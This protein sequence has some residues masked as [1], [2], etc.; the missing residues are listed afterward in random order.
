MKIVRARHHWNYSTTR[1]VLG[2]AKPTITHEGDNITLQ[3]QTAR[4]EYTSVVLNRDELDQALAAVH[5]AECLCND[6]YAK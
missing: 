4:G 5:P 2:N 1:D 6:P 3:I